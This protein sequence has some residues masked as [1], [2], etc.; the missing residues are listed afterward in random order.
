[1]RPAIGVAAELSALILSLIPMAFLPSSSIRLL[2]LLVA[3]GLAT[4]LIHC[5]AHYVTGSLMG[6]RFSDM[7]I[8]RTTLARALPSRLAPLA[9]LVPIVTLK[10]DKASLRGSSPSRGSLMFLSGVVASSGAAIIVAAVVAIGRN[11]IETAATVAFAIF[12]LFFD[13]AFSPKTGDVARARRFR[14]EASS[15]TD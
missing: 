8:G 2:Y 7:R 5:P 9:R 6:I 12:Y 14:R 15:R 1:M 3:Q 13:L 4:Y 11:P 10:A